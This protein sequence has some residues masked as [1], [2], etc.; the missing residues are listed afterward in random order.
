TLYVLILMGL[1]FASCDKEQPQPLTKEEI[2][3]KIDSLT[4]VQ[5]TESN[6]QAKRDLEHRIKIEVK[7]KVD[8]IL[9]AQLRQKT[10]DTT[11][12]KTSLFK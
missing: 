9:N 6:D 11:Q 1:M 12:K 3:K 8:S 4:K 5:V 10:K 2:N 7:V